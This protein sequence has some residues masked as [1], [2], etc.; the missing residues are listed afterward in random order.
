MQTITISKLKNNL[1]AEIKKLKKT[2]GLEVLQRD[3]P[4]ARLVPVEGHKGL[5]YYFRANK[6]FRFLRPI[7]EVNFDPLQILFEER[8]KGRV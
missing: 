3:V 7:V 4:V 6:K 5:R 2:G 8:Q 1:S